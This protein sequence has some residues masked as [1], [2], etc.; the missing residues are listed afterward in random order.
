MKSRPIVAAFF[1]ALCLLLCGL[2]L[3][4]QIAAHPLPP[5]SERHFDGDPQDLWSGLQGGH[6]AA[7]A[8]TAQ[9][10]QTVQGQLTA[11]RDGDGLKAM[12]YQ[13]RAMRRMSGN[14]GQFEQHIVSEYPEF[15]HCRHAH[16]W[17]VWTDKTGK[18][19]WMVVIAEGKNGHHARGIYQMVQ[20]DG[21]W[22]IN[23]VN[24]QRLPDSEPTPAQIPG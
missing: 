3:R 1:V 24:A 11:M 15:G 13:S 21:Q 7:P 2:I 8:M 19:A 23:D 14:P 10:R 16:F 4:R 6:V 9:V 20:E 12:S 22:K 18:M 5:V 17:P